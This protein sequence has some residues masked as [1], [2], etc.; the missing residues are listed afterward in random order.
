MRQLPP[1]LMNTNPATNAD[2]PWS[3]LRLS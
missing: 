1:T 2:S 3:H